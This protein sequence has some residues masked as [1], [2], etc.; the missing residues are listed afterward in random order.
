MRRGVWKV[1]VRMDFSRRAAGVHGWIGR[2]FL[3]TDG[4]LFSIGDG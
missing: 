2:C 4:K 1:V 3:M